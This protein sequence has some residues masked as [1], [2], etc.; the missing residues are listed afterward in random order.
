MDTMRSSRLSLTRVA[1]ALGI[2]AATPAWADQ[3]AP[4]TEGG[5]DEIVVTARK[6]SENLQTTPVAVTA[7]NQAALVQQ[8]V[9]DVADLQHAAPD[10]AIGGAGTG[11]SSIVYLA[12]RGQAQNMP[13]SL[14]DAS[15]GTYVDGVYLARAIVGNVGFL[16]VGQVEVLRGPQG[17]LFGR[18]T[19]GGALNITT[20]QPTDTFDGYVK[21][22]YGNYDAKL[23]EA[24]ANLP[25]V[26]GTLDARVAFRWD[27]HDS[28]YKNPVNSDFDAGGVDHEYNGRA[29]LK[30]TPSETPLTV[31][32]S[33]DYLD[34]FGSGTPTALTGVNT[35]STLGGGLPLSIGALLGLA[36]IDP[37]NYLVHPFNS[38][39]PNYKYSYGGVPLNAANPD[40]AIDKPFNE[41]RSEG[42]S[43]N[44]DLDIGAEHLKSITAYRWSDTL[45][46]ETL[47]GMPVNY[48]A[49][50]SEYVE[51]QF[52]QELQLS[53]KAGKFDWIGGA[54]FFEEGGSERSDSQAFGF[55]SP[56]FGIPAQ[57]IARDYGTFDS[58]S[59]AAFG[60][61]NYHFTDTI[62]ATLGYRYTWDYREI[63]EHNRND[64]L[65]ANLCA[66]GV[67]LNTPLAVAPNPCSAPSAAYF[68]Y[69]AWTAGLDWEVIPD[70]FVYVKTD[71]ASMAG[72]FNTR[73][74]P[75]GVSNAFGPESN[76]DVEL[77]VKV[78]TFEHHLRTNLALFHGWQND[79]Q[80][81]VNAVVVRN[82]T[83][84]VTQ[85]VTNA[86]KSNT[87]GLELEVTALPWTGMEINLSGSYLHAAYVAG[88]FHEQQLL[89]D[90][91]IA[92]VDRSNEPIPQA[93]KIT[94]SLGAT[95]SFPVA[96]GKVSVH[97]DYAWLDKIVYTV[98]TASPLQPA[99]V[100]A[101]YA[102]QNA[103]GVV[104]SY[105]LLNGRIA[106][107][108]DQP[109]VELALYGRNLT[110]K[111]YYTNQFDSYASLGVAENFQGNPRT[112]GGTVTYHFK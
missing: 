100:Q 41:T 63:D 37:N 50:T 61:T 13:N 111:E 53:G 88:T 94:Y 16:D 65:G 85:Y 3:A 101:A 22:G 11:P 77:G 23:G 28:Y 34:E 73:V 62:R 29:L 10:L 69:P 79:V 90:G 84:T 93:P 20:N 70:T 106:L 105:G 110:N 9:F 54:Y 95:Q 104:P 39:N 59:I 64:I 92:T 67:T 82:G 52:S 30:W 2:C 108:L 45:D 72:G 75:P 74:L 12:I 66:V 78:D 89:P 7:L 102:T 51:H 103:L 32:W 57:P 97:L 98:D 109:N 55:L 6:A 76:M 25:I 8:Q 87:Y 60:Q 43:Q 112:F 36:G 27:K 46:S 5:L 47:S 31:V 21:L 80:R 1:L 26:P 14:T 24:V 58:R 33:F 4:A 44:L 71:K 99:A 81:I 48:Y 19:P 35:T 96:M 49:F 38:P 107:N 17:T 18:N 86:G 56:L 83:T 91:T 15:V 68:S 40:P 42:F